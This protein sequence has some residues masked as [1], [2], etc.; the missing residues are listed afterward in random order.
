[1]AKID[2]RAKNVYLRFKPLLAML[3][4]PGRDTD[5]FP[6]SGLKALNEKLV[7]RSDHL[8]SRVCGLF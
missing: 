7:I 1:M 3:F 8:L 6:H 2:Q 5:N 4:T